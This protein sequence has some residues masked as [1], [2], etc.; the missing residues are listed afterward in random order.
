MSEKYG[1]HYVKFLT[2]LYRGSTLCVDYENVQYREPRPRYKWWAT[3]VSLNDS[4]VP[5][6]VQ[7]LVDMW[8]TSQYAG[9]TLSEFIRPLLEDATE[10]SNS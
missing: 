4:Q 9:L 1:R 2:G 6:D 5:P 10:D 8:E 7:K 3:A